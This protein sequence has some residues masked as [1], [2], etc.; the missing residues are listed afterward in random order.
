MRSEDTKVFIYNRW[1]NIPRRQFAIGD[2]GLS[3]NFSGRTIPAIDWEDA[4][5]IKES[6]DYIHKTLGYP[7]NFVLVNYYKDGDHSIGW[8]SDDERD[9]EKDQPI[10]SISLGVTREFR[11]MSKGSKDIYSCELVHN[12]CIEMH[13]PCQSIYKLC[14]PKS[15]KI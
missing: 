2:L 1:V 11:L 15:K 14:I 10:V 6:R 8:H 9:L 4:P 7:V 5:I 12:S 13:P 3:Y